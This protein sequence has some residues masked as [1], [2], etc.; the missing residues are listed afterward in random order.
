MKNIL[1]S[2][3]V[4][5]LAA[6]GAQAAIINL[7]LPGNGTHVDGSVFTTTSASFGGAT[8]DIQYT[9][10]AVAG[11]ETNVDAFIQ[12]NGTLF[13]VGSEPDG[14]NVNQQ[15]SVDGGDGE[16][17]SFTNLSITNFNSGTSSLVVGDLKMA[18]DSV[19]FTNGANAP[20]GVSFSFTDFGVADEDVTSPTTVD[21]TSLS[22]FDASST[23]LFLEP[24]NDAFNNRWSLSGISVSVVPEPSSF[25]MLGGIGGLLMLCRR[26]H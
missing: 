6:G 13:G 4:C 16:K 23:S 5:L 2:L 3:C 21:L 25:A 9:L 24:D 26:K 19:T 22:N 14:A 20:D 10:N 11:D 15:Q 12:S 7:D 1:C 18:F 17:V 8:F